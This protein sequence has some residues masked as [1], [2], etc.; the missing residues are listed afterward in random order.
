[1]ALDCTRL[2]EAERWRRQSSNERAVAGAMRTLLRS[3]HS[4]LLSCIHAFVHSCISS[5]KLFIHAFNVPSMLH[6]IFRTHYS[7]SRV[8]CSFAKCERVV[9]EF[10]C[11]YL[12]LSLSSIHYT[13]A[14][15]ADTSWSCCWSSSSNAWPSLLPTDATTRALRKFPK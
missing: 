7:R 1:M 5:F 3:A 8:G 10:V 14:A 13:E 9:C 12:S 2:S 15:S 4:L 11:I 6:S